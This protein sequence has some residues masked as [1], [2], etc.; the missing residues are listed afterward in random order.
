MNNLNNRV[1]ITHKIPSCRSRISQVYTHLPI[2]I[3]YQHGK[4]AEEVLYG[5]CGAVWQTNLCAACSIV[6]IYIKYTKSLCFAACILQCLLVHY[7]KVYLTT[8]NSEVCCSGQYC[9]VYLYKY[10]NNH[11]VPFATS[12]ST[13]RK[14]YQLHPLV[15]FIIII[16]FIHIVN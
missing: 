9:I 7:I 16:T 6:Q 15:P 5:C 10:I 11:E 13:L 8:R 4:S 2:Y 14:L 1:I 3:L 12:P